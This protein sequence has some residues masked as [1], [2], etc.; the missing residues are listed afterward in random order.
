MATAAYGPIGDAVA[1]HRSSGS[2][3]FGPIGDPVA[4][5]RNSGSVERMDLPTWDLS[6][7]AVVNVALMPDIILPVSHGMM[8]QKGEPPQATGNAY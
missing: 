8:E 6:S 2:A 4:A 1:A 5:Y 3:V 7:G